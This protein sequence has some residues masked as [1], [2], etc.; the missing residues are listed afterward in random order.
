[1]LQFSVHFVSLVYLVDEAKRVSD[2]IGEP[3]PDPDSEFKPSLLN[4]TVYII[5]IALQ[6][7][8][9]AVNYK[10]RPFME[11]LIENRPLLYSVSGSILAI[12]TLVTNLAPELTQQFSIVEFPPAV[13]FPTFIREKI[14]F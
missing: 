11:S 9:F 10:G 2:E 8:T 3:R 13:S 7:S 12:F 5:S 4:S 14:H 1:M 6:V